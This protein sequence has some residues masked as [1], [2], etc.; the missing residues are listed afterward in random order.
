MNKKM[1]KGI[2][3]IG[4]NRHESTN[5]K[6]VRLL[7]RTSQDYFIKLIVYFIFYKNVSAIKLTF[8]LNT[9]KKVK[10][11]SHFECNNSHTHIQLRRLCSIRVES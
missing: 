6:H 10:T 3:L 9:L 2:S 4:G 7:K 8:C 1:I 11:P 5:I